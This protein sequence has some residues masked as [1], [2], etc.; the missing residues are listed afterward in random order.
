MV[1][2][3]FCL[4][5]SC[6][7]IRS[8]HFGLSISKSTLAIPQRAIVRIRR[9]ILQI[10]ICGLFQAAE[11][12]VEEVV[13]LQRRELVF[14]RAARDYD[15]GGA[16]DYIAFH[17]AHQPAEL[18]NRL[19]LLNDE[20]PGL[21]TIVLDVHKHLYQ[22]GCSYAEREVGRPRRLRGAG[23]RLLQV[24]GEGHLRRVSVAVICVDQ[25]R[26]IQSG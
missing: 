15:C 1:A 5:A 4:T 9:L 13:A 8:F 21:A 14:Q 11:R 20:W 22:C 6:A 18:S 12:E 17:L 10:H 7:S 3:R 24:F 2:L 23:G 25:V 26:L 19:E 16:Q